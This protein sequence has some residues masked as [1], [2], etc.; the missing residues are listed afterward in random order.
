[1]AKILVVI[2]AF[3]EAESLTR[4]LPKFKGCLYNIL[5]IDDG[6]TDHTKDVLLNLS[7]NYI[8][9]SQNLGQGAALMT[10]MKYANDGNYDIVVHFD[11]DGQHQVPDIATLITPLLTNQYDIA[12]GSRFLKRETISRIPFRRRALLRIARYVDFAFSGILLSDVH[13][14]LRA[15]NRNAFSQMNLTLPRMAHASQILQEI[16][17]LGLRYKE[18]PVDIVYFEQKHKKGQSLIVAFGI[19][20]DLLKHKLKHVVPRP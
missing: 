11:A 2:P 13:N 7:A 12:L 1:M 8:C 14:G 17:R 4:I 5:V 20:L 16:K 15:L 6:S 10:G 3:N 9:H 19:V 18:V